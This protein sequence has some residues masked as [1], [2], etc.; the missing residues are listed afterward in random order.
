MEGEFREDLL[1]RLNVLPIRIPPLNQRK[2]DI[3]ELLDHFAETFAVNDK[4]ISFTRRS[5]LLLQAY[6]WPGNVREL[7]NL[8]QRFSVLYPGKTLELSKIPEE[9]LSQELIQITR[10]SEDSSIEEQSDVKR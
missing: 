10:F 9:F 4:R 3:P 2:E 8:V 7:S 6:S 1:Y 5:L